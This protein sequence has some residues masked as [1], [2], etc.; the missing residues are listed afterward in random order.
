MPQLI[1]ICVAV[2]LLSSGNPIQQPSNRLLLH[3]IVKES[4]IFS[5]N[6]L[7]QH[8]YL[9]PTITISIMQS[10]NFLWLVTEK[11][12]IHFLISNQRKQR[13]VRFRDSI[14]NKYTLTLFW[15]SGEVDSVKNRWILYWIFFCLLWFICYKRA[16]E[17]GL[18]KDSLRGN[19]GTLNSQN[20]I[21]YNKIK[22]NQ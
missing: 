17:I 2:S 21:L 11:V 22:T 6:S 10:C 18:L 7:A 9:H 3:R 16:N 4:F 15:T 8:H 14:K 5:T 1:P 19:L 20:M 13:V 12:S